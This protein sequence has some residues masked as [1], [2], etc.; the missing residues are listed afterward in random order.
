[1]IRKHIT[2]SL[3]L[4]IIALIVASSGIAEAA[5]H[6]VKH[7]FD[8]TIDGHRVS[9]RPYAGGVLLLGKNKKFAAAAIPTVSDASRLG[10]KT[11]AALEPACPSGT[12]SLG[13][14]CLEESIYPVPMQDAGQ[15]DYF[16]ASQTC[17]ERGGFLPSAS[18]LVGAV[19][20][21]KL[22]GQGQREMSSTLI[23]TEAGSEA[24][25]SEGVS[26][27]ATGNPRTGE[28]NPV[29]IPAVPE[30]ETAQ[31]VTV[32]ANG[33]RGGLA[34]SEPVSKAENF[35]CGYFKIP[36]A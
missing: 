29:P 19:K 1:M 22:E 5:R 36:A 35:R 11:L 10:G 3:V 33:Q 34:G 20:S 32:F 13:T 24:A 18:E 31:Y 9:A 7:A 28:P 23:T 25:G 16:W 17:T 4:S 8:V 2:P 21:V 27:G 30:P 6:A 15:N 26:E 12:A 14:W